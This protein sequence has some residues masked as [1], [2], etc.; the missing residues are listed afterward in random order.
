MTDLRIDS[1]AA[2]AELAKRGHD[3]VRALLPEL[4]TGLRRRLH[5]RRRERPMVRKNPGGRGRC[6]DLSQL[7][8]VLDDQDAPE[9]FSGSI[10][11]YS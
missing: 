1:S 8:F 6:Q 7:S 11:R 10:R 3:K 9:D 2:I 4:P 5:D